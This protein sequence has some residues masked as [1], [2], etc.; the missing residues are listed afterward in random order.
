MRTLAISSI[1][2]NSPSTKMT[3]PCSS[4]S[5]HRSRGSRRLFEDMER[6]L[7]NS[8]SSGYSCEGR[9]LG[10]RGLP[11]VAAALPHSL[12]CQVVPGGA[13]DFSS[14]FDLR[15]IDV[16]LK[17]AFVLPKPL[18]LGSRRRVQSISKVGSRVVA[19]RWQVENARDDFLGVLYAR[20]HDEGIAKERWTRLCD[21]LKSAA[22]DSDW[23]RRNRSR[24][25]EGTGVRN[26]GSI[27][28]VGGGRRDSSRH[29]PG[30]G[31][32]GHKTGQSMFW[33]R[34]S[35]SWSSELYDAS[36]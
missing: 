13:V 7:V 28:A 36:D 34:W 6:P 18:F 11:P 1:F 21:G 2:L 17:E 30:I 35:R 22:S 27:A 16:V 33:S 15:E 9:S 24:L 20:R 10:F 12:S 31:C 8:D 4:T 26:A 14:F 25:R 32:D 23:E 29:Q 19:R 3:V 5:V